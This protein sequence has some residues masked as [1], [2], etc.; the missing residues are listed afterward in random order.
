MRFE[1]RPDGR[2]REIVG[3]SQ[4]MLDLFSSRRRAYRAQGRADDSGV[5]A[6][7]MGGTR[8]AE[9]RYISQQATLATRAAK[10]H[11]GETRR[12]AP[13]AVDRAG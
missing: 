1:T 12:A 2:A 11:D 7:G 4:E 9:L 6:T 10:T 13:G 3:V 5:S 8:P